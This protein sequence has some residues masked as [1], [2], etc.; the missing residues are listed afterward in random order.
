[1]ECIHPYSSSEYSKGQSNKANCLEELHCKEIENL[2]VQH[3]ATI[4]SSFYR[5]IYRTAKYQR[6]FENLEINRPTSSQPET[7]VN[8]IV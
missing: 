4:K 5:G 6:I 7:A 8:A 3:G 2:L 1:M